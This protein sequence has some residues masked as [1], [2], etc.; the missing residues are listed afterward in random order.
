MSILPLLIYLFYKKTR[1]D[2]LSFVLFALGLCIVGLSLYPAKNYIQAVISDDPCATKRLVIK[3]YSELRTEVHDSVVCI[4]KDRG[5]PSETYKGEVLNSADAKT[6]ENLNDEYSRDKRTV[7]YEGVPIEG[8]DPKTFIIN[9]LWKT[10]QPIESLEHYWT[11]YARDSNNIYFEGK[12]VAAKNIEQFKIIDLCNSNLCATDG[13][14]VFKEGRVLS[15]IDIQSLRMFNICEYA[16]DNK[17]VYYSGLPIEDPIDVS[18]FNI[19]SEA[20]FCYAFDDSSHLYYKG[21]L[22]PGANPITFEKVS[23][24]DPFSPYTDGKGIYYDGKRLDIDINMYHYLGKGV[25][26]DTSSVYHGAD[27]IEGADAATFELIP[28]SMSQAL[29]VCA[30]DK[31]HMYFDGEVY[32]HPLCTG[33]LY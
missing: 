11:P 2:K 31:N 7:F 20:Y 9:P 10:E 16:K 18:T 17:R 23:P 30:K 12:K 32:E 3:G 26:K 13:V 25:S 6:F 21:Q 8:A 24:Y 4:A 19:Y 5:Y 1:G 28:V 27:K 29:N 15:G 14:Q 33:E 22:V